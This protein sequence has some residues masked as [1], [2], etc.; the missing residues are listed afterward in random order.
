MAPLL[1]QATKSP[2]PNNEKALRIIARSLFRELKDYGYSPHQIVSL[3]SELISLVTTDIQDE[4]G[5]EEVR[6]AS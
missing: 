5:V 3:S 1:A 4:P 6:K 2:K